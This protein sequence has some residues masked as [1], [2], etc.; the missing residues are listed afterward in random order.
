MKK[1]IKL[2]KLFVLFIILL[3]S[4]IALAFDPMLANQSL[5]ELTVTLSTQ[6]LSKEALHKTQK[7]LIDLKRQA[8]QCIEEKT[9]EL[10]D[11]NAQLPEIQD[12]ESATTD[13]TFLL[14]RKNEINLTLSGCKVYSFKANET[15][16]IISRQAKEVKKSFYTTRSDPLWKYW[17]S[18]FTSTKV[19]LEQLEA[20]QLSIRIDPQ[21]YTY[22]DLIFII[23]LLIFSYVLSR[24]I[25]VIITFLSAYTQE[26]SEFEKYI[27][28][29]LKCIKSRTH[30]ILS[31]LALLMYET[32]H[33]YVTDND[34]LFDD[35]L[36][37]ILLF[38]I[39]QVFVEF[40][41]SPPFSTNYFNGKKKVEIKK[42]EWAINILL[43][44]LLVKYF[45]YQAFIYLP[46]E[47]MLWKITNAIYYTALTLSFVWLISI[48][49]KLFSYLDTHPII[50]ALGTVINYV[51]LIFIL[52]T[53]WDGYFPLSQYVMKGV[54][55]TL[56]SIIITIMLYTSS[57]GLLESLIEQ[58]HA[59][60]K[61]AF[62]FIQYS[63]NDLMLELITLKLTLLLLLWGG[64]IVYLNDIWSISD[65]WPI[66]LREYI[67][68]GVLV[69]DTKI[70]PIRIIIALM[71]FSFLTLLIKFIKHHLQPRENATNKAAQDAYLII[72]GYIGV[73]IAIILSLLIAGVDLRG[74]AI[75]AGALSF[76]IGFGLQNIVNNFIS[77]LVLLIERPI[78]KGDRIIVGDKEG[79]VTQVGVRSTH[80]Q[81]LE[82]SH[83]IVPNSDLIT[84]KVKNFMLNNKR[85]RIK[86]D[87]VVQHDTPPTE[88]KALLLQAALAH[89]EIIKDG[90]DAPTVF[91]LGY[92]NSALNFS[93]WC[94][95]DN[96]NNKFYIRS[97]L[98]FAIDALFRENNIRYAFTQT[99][100][101][102]KEGSS[103]SLKA[104]SDK[105]D[106]D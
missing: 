31:L 7:E 70:Q 106:H 28:S 49:L 84:K 3:D 56:A 32:L 14:T 63:K 72:L 9:K 60:Q 54:M 59:W 61:R 43:I 98:Y 16:S 64:L 41:T 105:K 95:I 91:C 38:Y 67:F 11:V 4:S 100:L 1:V 39:A 85:F 76:G 13:L 34:L 88:V 52:F 23:I 24:Y 2:I 44:T 27:F 40:I 62:R 86:L 78:K 74:L 82:L 12:D 36:L 90:S 37:P 58:R 6:I 69:F 104:N 92:Y 47:E 55:F 46:A 89:D 29:F 79:F 8:D 35:F 83:L 103:L 22:L 68:S 33:D 19:W 94:S 66:Q 45:F 18:L 65:L 57:V 10:A 53:L 96:V 25:N 102:I 21:S 81:T 97:D 26:K 15:L 99:D 30:I 50:K 71:L 20:S 101:H 48:F 51:F 77:G 42:L 17:P 87:I 5:D 75:I 80:V 73:S 93:L